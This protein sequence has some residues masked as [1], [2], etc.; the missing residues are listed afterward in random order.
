MPFFMNYD[1]FSIDIGRVIFYFP[2]TFFLFNE[3]VRDVIYNLVCLF[4]SGRELFLYCVPFYNYYV[5]FR[6]LSNLLKFDIRDF[7]V[8]AF[9]CLNDSS[10]HVF[11][12][13]YLDFRVELRKCSTSFYFIDFLFYIKDSKRYYCSY[14]REKELDCLGFSLWK[15]LS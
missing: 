12:L 5:L 11:Y 9:G 15:S 13:S 10:L 2:F 3:L 14:S 4:K 1:Y 7:E 8:I 6:L